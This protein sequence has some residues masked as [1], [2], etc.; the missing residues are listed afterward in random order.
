LTE[1]FETGFLTF[2]SVT[3]QYTVDIIVI[4]ACGEVDGMRIGRGN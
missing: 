3:I 2:L 4:N 1:V